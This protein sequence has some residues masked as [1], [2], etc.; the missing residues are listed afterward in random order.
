VKNNLGPNKRQMKKK[1][2][3]F[4]DRMNPILCIKISLCKTLIRKKEICG[5]TN[6]LRLII[7]YLKDKENEIMTYTLNSKCSSGWLFS[8]LGSLEGM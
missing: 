1:V 6:S 7:K 4:H 8:C 5:R 2:L 3:Q